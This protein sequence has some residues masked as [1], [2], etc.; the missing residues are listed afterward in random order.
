MYLMIWKNH[1]KTNRSRTIKENV[2]T[3]ANKQDADGIKTRE[4]IARYQLTRDRRMLF[5][6][7]MCCKNRV[8]V[9]PLH[10]YYLN[11]FLMW[12]SRQKK[13]I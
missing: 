9:Y 12:C 7:M 5:L 2:R 6:A 10:T 4:M 13:E 1:I 11:I 8:R 3:R